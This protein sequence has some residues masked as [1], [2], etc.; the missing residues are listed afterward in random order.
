MRGPFC[1]IMAPMRQYYFSAL[2]ALCCL[3]NVSCTTLSYERSSQADAIASEAG[4]TRIIVRTDPF[5]LTAYYHLSA[6]GKPINIYIEGDGYA[7]VTPSRPSGDPTPQNPV[8]LRLAT[9]DRGANVVY[10]ARPCQFTPEDENPAC[11]T[12]YWT[13]G[14]FSDEVVNSMD[15]AISYF[16]K[17][18]G[19]SDIHLIGYS[20][21]AAV[22]ILITARRNDIRSLRT[23]AGNLDPETVNRHHGASALEGSLD[24]A[25]VASKTAS[26][27]Q[28]HFVGGR[29][30]V[31]PLE[32]A[33][34]FSQKMGESK[35]FQ[36]KTIPSAT[37]TDG[38]VENWS[39]ML[40]LPI[41]CEE[42]R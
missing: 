33:E 37:H 38:W 26:I 7:W 39:R 10:L 8:G 23:V 14:R 42:A 40:G 1:F 5:A 41:L 30:K 35:C 34:V 6:L 3:V 27:P 21:G 29:D 18:A 19:T 16:A 17:K 28:L 12:F 25:V 2:I 11:E 20:G 13:D 32:T 22:A 24:P 4:L 36:T 31:I 9:Q 15:Q